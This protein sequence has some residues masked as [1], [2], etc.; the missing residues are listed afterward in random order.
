MKAVIRA[1]LLDQEAR[2]LYHMEDAAHGKM[3]EPFLRYVKL[4]R[5]MDA[6]DYY[7][8]YLKADIWIGQ[9]LGQR[10]FSAPSV[11]NFFLPDHQPVGAIADAGLVAPEFQI[12][13]SQTIPS[14]V[15][16]FQGVLWQGLSD[17]DE[18]EPETVNEEGEPIGRVGRI[19]W[20][21]PWFFDTSRVEPLASDAEALVDHLDLLLAN[22][23]LTDSTKQTIIDTIQ[24]LG[25]WDEEYG[26]RIMLAMYL[27]LLS[28]D[29]TISK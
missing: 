13:N 8:E 17:R 2:N 18:F 10:P 4:L 3:R 7:G 25:V 28:P 11:F 1:I 21:N 29:F 27:I 9:Q 23:S 26:V 20:G 16:F 5:A 24:P 6:V 12:T 19:L 15:N 14:T 22:G